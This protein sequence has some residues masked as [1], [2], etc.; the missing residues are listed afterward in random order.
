MTLSYKISTSGGPSLETIIVSVLGDSG[1][2]VAE[3]HKSPA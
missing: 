2:K 3:G 1:S